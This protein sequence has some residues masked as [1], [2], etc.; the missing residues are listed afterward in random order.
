MV[1][2]ALEK[3]RRQTYRLDVIITS[4][5]YSGASPVGTMPWDVHFVKPEDKPVF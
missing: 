5:R 3:C 4:Q 1:A 2:A